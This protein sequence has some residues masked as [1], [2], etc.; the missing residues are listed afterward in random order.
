[1]KITKTAQFGVLKEIL[2]QTKKEASAMVEK[3]ANNFVHIRKTKQE[4]WFQL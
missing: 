4:L 1:L 3:L 2:L